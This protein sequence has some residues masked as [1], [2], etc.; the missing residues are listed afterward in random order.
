MNDLF[1]PRIADA[2]SELTIDA[3]VDGDAEPDE[4]AAVEAWMAADPANA[5]LVEARRSGWDAMP[6]AR[7]QAML[8]RIRQGLEAAEAET[9]REAT[10]PAARGGRF[11]LRQW[12]FGGLALAGAAAAVYLAVGRPAGIEGSTDVV[13]TKGNLALEVFR[14]RGDEVT[15]LVSGDSATAGDRLRF[16]VENVPEGPGQLMVV[17][18]EAGGAVFPYFPDGGRS[19]AAHGTI[20]ADRSL[21]GAAELDDSVGRERIWLVWCPTGFAT[22]DLK[23]TNE[24]L[25]TRDANCRTAGFTLEKK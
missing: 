8:A 9:R 16:V 3:Y 14:A 22:A 12:I 10:P 25:R 11:S 24:G 19:I 20:R 6:E 15:A 13:L 1:D 18:V 17:G 7:P 21:P 4:V 5:A 23:A 2:P